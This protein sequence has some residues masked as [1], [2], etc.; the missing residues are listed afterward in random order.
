MLLIDT[1]LFIWAQVWDCSNTLLNLVE[2]SGGEREMSRKQ[3]KSKAEKGIHSSRAREIRLEEKKK[4]GSKI[5]EITQPVSVIPWD[6][7][8]NLKGVRLILPC[9]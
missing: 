4:T 2:Y 5:L 8:I 3:C 1:G 7:K 9:Q 6:I